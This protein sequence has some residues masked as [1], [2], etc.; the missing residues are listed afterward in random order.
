M[1]RRK[2]TLGEQIRFTLA[3]IRV[4]DEVDRELGELMIAA[5]SDDSLW[6]KVHVRL[7]V[8]GRFDQADWLRQIVAGK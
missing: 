5:S 7:N 3:A 2:F 6:P 1:L 8:I 4:R